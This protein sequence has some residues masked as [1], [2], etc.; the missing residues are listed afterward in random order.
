MSDKHRRHEHV[1]LFV[2]TILLAA[3]MMSCSGQDYGFLQP[4]PENLCKCLPV[5][6]DILDYRHAAKH[7]PIANV[8]PQEVSVETILTWPQDIFIP[9]DAPRSGR[10]L[11]VFHIANAFLQKASVN[12]LD[13]DVSME[14]SQT[15]DKSSLR[16]IVETPVDGEYCSARQTLQ[17]QLG[18]HGFRLDSQHGGELPQALPIDVVGMAFEDFEHDRGPVATLWEIHPAIVTIH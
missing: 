1:Y 16:M 10:E 2:M 6:P 9:A 15:A 8:A 12:A 17:A 3:S 4:N 5:E 14:I 11:E 7:V 18:K 13:C